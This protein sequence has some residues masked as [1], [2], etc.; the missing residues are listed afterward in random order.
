MAAKD[1]PKQTAPT[2]C[3]QPPELVELCVEH[4]PYEECTW[5]N[6]CD[7]YKRIRQA[8]LE[9]KSFEFP[10]L[11]QPP[12]PKPKPESEITDPQ[13]L[14]DMAWKKMG[15]EVTGPH[16]LTDNHVRWSSPEPAIIVEP[17]DILSK[18]EQAEQ[19]QTLKHLNRAI[20]DLGIVLTGLWG[21]VDISDMVDNLRSIRT[22]HF[23]HLVDWDAVAGGKHED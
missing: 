13:A 12:E 23:E 15:A 5:H 21:E 16:Q 4:C 3:D 11:W 1:K 20:S 7:H 10:Q 9:G 2:Y 17:V 14:F 22:K 8:I 6:G 18:P 19:R